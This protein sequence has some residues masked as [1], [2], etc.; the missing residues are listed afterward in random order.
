[1][2]NEQIA[3]VLRQ[4]ADL[5]EMK[6][7]VRFK[8]VAFQK[9]ARAVAYATD[10]VEKL[11]S[12]G[13]L[14]EIP[15]VGKG[16]AS[17]IDELLSN[18]RIEEHDR[19]VAIISHLP[20]AMAAL[21]VDMADEHRAISV[22]ATG[23]RDTTRVAS[24]DPQVWTDIFTTNREAVLEA[25]DLLGGRLAELRRVIAEGDEDQVFAWLERAKTARDRWL[26][27]GVREP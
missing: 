22:A 18:G 2:N 15:G 16:I 4:M 26:T 9:V 1:M 19:L 6:G 23:F 12:E 24:G 13:R 17:K 10:D 20:H 3:G 11:A 5:L 25:V 27:E 21:M 7:E 8:V 14:R